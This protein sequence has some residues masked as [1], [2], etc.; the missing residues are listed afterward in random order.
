MQDNTVPLQQHPEY[1][2]CVPGSGPIALLANVSTERA[3]REVQ[4]KMFMADSEEPVDDSLLDNSPPVG[5]TQPMRVFSPSLF[6]GMVCR[7]FLLPST[8]KLC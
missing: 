1:Y 3:D 5:S 7:V 8:Q 4:A 6:T 2:L